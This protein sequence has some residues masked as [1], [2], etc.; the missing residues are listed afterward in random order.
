MN[1][2]QRIGFINSFIV[3]STRPCTKI[4]CLILNVIAYIHFSPHF[5]YSERCLPETNKLVVQ[6]V[7]VVLIK[8]IL[9]VKTKAV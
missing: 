2:C 3:D 5:I 9:Y 1:F 7:L 8:M 4:G 6:N